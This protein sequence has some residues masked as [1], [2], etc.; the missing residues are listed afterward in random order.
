[1]CMTLDSLM[2]WHVPCTAKHSKA[3]Q[4]TAKAIPHASPMATAMVSVVS[5]P[6][7]TSSFTSRPPEAVDACKADPEHTFNCIAELL[8]LIL[9]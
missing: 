1:M 5:H 7:Y 6:R 9:T 3:Q 8:S 4:S 2:C